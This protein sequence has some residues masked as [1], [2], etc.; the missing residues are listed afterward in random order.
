VSGE[1]SFS[2]KGLYKDVALGR[3]KLTD[4]A[5]V[6][7]RPTVFFSTADFYSWVTRQE[8]KNER[9]IVTPKWA[10]GFPISSGADDGPQQENPRPKWARFTGTILPGSLLWFTS[11]AI[12]AVGTTT[13]TQLL[14]SAPEQ[15]ITL[16]ESEPI[17]TS[18]VE[19]F[20]N[21]LRVVVNGRRYVAAI[22]RHA[23]G[24]AIITGAA[25]LTSQV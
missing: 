18:F 25:Y 22:T 24:T 16:C 10:P 8:D 21:T 20:A 13:K 23:G 2:V 14:V 4:T 15:S 12:P 17:I 6:R 11:D 19:T 1:A 9:P 7:L 5:G 3:E